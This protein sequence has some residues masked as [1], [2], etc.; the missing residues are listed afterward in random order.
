MSDGPRDLV[1]GV[2]E[3]VL[4]SLEEEVEVILRPFGKVVV[5]VDVG[6]VG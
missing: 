6:H 4:E 3:N 5:E 1:S 2:P